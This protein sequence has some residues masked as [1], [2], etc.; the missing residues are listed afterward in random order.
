MPAKKRKTTKKK[1]VAT[2]GAKLHK[3]VVKQ[4][5]Q[6]KKRAKESESCLS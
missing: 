1:K 6:L 3:K 2:V 5:D 4:R